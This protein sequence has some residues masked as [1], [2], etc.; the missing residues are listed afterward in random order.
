MIWTLALPPWRRLAAE[1]YLAVGP[2]VRWRARGDRLRDAIPGRES[3]I[4]N[5]FQFSGTKLSVAAL[6]RDLDAGD[7]TG[8][9]WLR[10]DPAYIQADMATARLM[11]CGELG[12]SREECV[13]LVQP[14]QPLFGDAGFPLEATTTSR[15][16]L[17]CPR[18]A[19]L[20][21]FSTPDQALG[22]D[23][24]D[25]LPAGDVGRR[26]RGL[27]TE[28]QVL[29]H[30]HPVNRQRVARGQIPVNAL[31]FWGAGLLPEWVKSSVMAV[32][33]GDATVRALARRAGVAIHTLTEA[34]TGDG[35]VFID[36]A[37]MHDMETVATWVERAEVALMTKHITTLQL[38]FDSGERWHLTR[39]QRW[40]FWRRAQPLSTA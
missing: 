27:F 34:P 25:H 26:W 39:S 30:N 4:R 15:W 10:A 17:R 32:H 33:S 9:L 1:S 16:Y 35:E 18:G 29:L 31:W 5:I 23:L 40:R 11:A 36:L 24:G 7:T 13:A 2:L 21:P 8:S 14:L 6:T 22:N 19:K 37:A 28:A 3:L 12:L 20:P 38:A